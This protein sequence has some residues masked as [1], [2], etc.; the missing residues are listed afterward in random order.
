MVV[1]NYSGKLENVYIGDLMA[2][3]YKME[4]YTKPVHSS[5]FCSFERHEC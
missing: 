4:I 2:N 1:E 3:L 5:G